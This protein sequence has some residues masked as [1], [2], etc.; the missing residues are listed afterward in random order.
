MTFP[1]NRLNSLTLS[2]VSDRPKME[3]EY[4]SRFNTVKRFIFNTKVIFCMN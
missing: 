3:R 4:D 2:Q 1:A